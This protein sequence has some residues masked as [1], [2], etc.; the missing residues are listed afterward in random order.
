VTPDYAV[1]DNQQ[2]YKKAFSKEN[3]KLSKGILLALSKPNRSI[4]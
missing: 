2:G 4:S 3:Q 1:K